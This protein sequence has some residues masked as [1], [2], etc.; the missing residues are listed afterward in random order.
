MANAAQHTDRVRDRVEAKH[1]HRAALRFQQTEDVFD[2]GG[3]ARAVFAD[4]SEDH[5]ARNT[6]RYVVESE[7]GTET[8]A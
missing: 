2:E 8:A 1:A 3:F 7:S 6:E 5:A 4:Q